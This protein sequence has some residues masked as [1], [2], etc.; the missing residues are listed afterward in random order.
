VRNSCSNDTITLEDLGK[1]I[2]GDVGGGV[3]VVDSGPHLDAMYQTGPR[4]DFQTVSQPDG[5][6]GRFWT[7]VHQIREILETSDEWP[8][9]PIEIDGEYL[10]DGH[11]RSNAAI[12]AGWDK[13]IPVEVW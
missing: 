6:V 9:P 3:R 2:A 7:K 12:L 1:L 13:P 11:H 8:F 4:Y 5:A 10:L